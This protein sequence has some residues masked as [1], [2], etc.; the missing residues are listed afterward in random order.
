MTLLTGASRPSG[1]VWSMFKLIR[2]YLYLV[3]SPRPGPEISEIASVKL[4][5]QKVFD[6]HQGQP[7]RPFGLINSG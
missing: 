4:V 5:R 3:I 1:I 7:S 6:L 2:S